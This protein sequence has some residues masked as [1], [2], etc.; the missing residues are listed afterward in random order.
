MAPK[1]KHLTQKQV[2]SPPNLP[3]RQKPSF[4]TNFRTA[5]AQTRFDDTF[6]HQDVKVRRVIRFELLESINFPYLS[7]F[8]E[9]RWT[10]YLKMNAPVYENLVRAFYYNSELVS[11]HNTPNRSYSDRF[12]TFLM[13]NEYVILR[14]VIADALNLDDSG[15]TNTKADILDLAKSVFDDESLPFAHT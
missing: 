12:K 9:F 3:K 6:A 1:V 8:E 13:G 2:A 14:Q 7:T 5:I 11:R 10:N 15:E 4:R